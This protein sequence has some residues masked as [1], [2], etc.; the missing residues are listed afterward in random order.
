M[1]SNSLLHVEFCYRDEIRLETFDFWDR[2]FAAP[3]SAAKSTDAF[4]YGGRPL[5]Y[6]QH[7]FEANE[8]EPLRTPIEASVVDI[9]D[10]SIGVLRFEAMNSDSVSLSVEASLRWNESILDVT[11]TLSNR[12]DRNVIA[13]PVE[14]IRF[15][16]AFGATGAPNTNFHLFTPIDKT[17]TDIDAV[18]F[19]VGSS[20]PQ[21]QLLDEINTL[22]T[23]YRNRASQA[24]FNRGGDWI[25]AQIGPSAACC[26]IDFRYPQSLQQVENNLIVF[27]DHYPIHGDDPHKPYA[28]GA[29]FVH[30]RVDIPSGESFTYNQTWSG[31]VAPSPV[32]DVENGVPFFQRMKAMAHFNNFYFIGAM[33]APLEGRAAI[34]L[35]APDGEIIC[36]EP[37]YVINPSLQSGTYQ[38]SAKH[39]LLVSS[40][41]SFGVP[42]D[43]DPQNI[44]PWMWERTRWARLVVTDEQRRVLRV[45]DETQEPWELFDQ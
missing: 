24:A 2:R 16:A 32:S 41:L 17:I 42:D 23:I 34:Q 5:L 36:T 19:P 7:P 28:L 39:P 33:G 31:S 22:Q 6:S 40:Q 15:N 20:E 12:S 27:T 10:P 14:E 4:E 43:Y 18:S 9:G 37:L 25:A 21:Y 3:A 1:L 11:T 45:L 13:Y 26:A 8:P 38:V 29:Q 44:E 35:V 30:G